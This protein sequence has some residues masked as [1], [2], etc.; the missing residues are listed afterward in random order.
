MNP[1][2]SN[3]SSDVVRVELDRRLSDLG[4]AFEADALT[5]IGRIGWGF[6]KPI[7][8]T[9][10]EYRQQH[11]RLVVILETVG[12][13]IE[14]V[15]RIVT[16]IRKHYSNVGFIIPDF[17]MS[18]GTVLAM[19]GDAIH[20]DYYSIL[21]PIDPQVRNREGVWVPALGYLRQYNRLIDK[22]ASGALTDAEMAF[23]LKNFDT[24]ELY[25]YEQARELTI[26][27]LKIWLVQYKFKNWTKTESEGREV[28]PE[29]R[30]KRAE[31]IAKK[32]N[33]T[34]HWRSHGRGISKDVLE[35]D[36]ELKIEDFGEIE[37]QRLRIRCYYDM[38]QDYMLKH[39][40][41]WLVHMDGICKPT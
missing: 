38:A 8:E 5:I 18:A 4:N 9:L 30:E 34:D 32:L 15:E 3:D 24:A 21:G 6:A 28:T 20:M 35:R 31:E 23:L 27:L 40:Y 1:E 39:Q 2:S 16:V 10:E 11:D 7:R 26:S 17:A 13:V 36:L 41:S 14:E 19:S 25:S 29:I 37:Q 33:E 12:G 22:S